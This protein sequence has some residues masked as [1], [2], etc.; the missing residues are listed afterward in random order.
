MSTELVNIKKELIKNINEAYD[1]IITENEIAEDEIAIISILKESLIAG[2]LK[3]TIPEVDAIFLM[4]NL[5]LYK[6]I[7]KATLAMDEEKIIKYSLE[8][9]KA[10]NEYDVNK[11]SI[12][13]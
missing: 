2:A 10:K 13:K 4:Q 12:Q 11:L 3:E 5:E 6:N 7:I 8:T 1:E 9:L